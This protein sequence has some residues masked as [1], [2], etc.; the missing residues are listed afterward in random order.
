M[1]VL[2][3]SRLAPLLKGRL[4][5]ARFGSGVN[6]TAVL[7]ALRTVAPGEAGISK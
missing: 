1:G 3:P 7:V 5:A 4:L 2:S 6:S